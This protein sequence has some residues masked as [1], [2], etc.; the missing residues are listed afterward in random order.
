VAGYYYQQEH[1]SWVWLVVHPG[2]Y[3]HNIHLIE[4]EQAPHSLLQQKR[5]VGGKGMGPAQNDLSF[6]SLYNHFLEG[7]GHR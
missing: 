3:D 1:H 2:G 5:K 7:E 4:E 6:T